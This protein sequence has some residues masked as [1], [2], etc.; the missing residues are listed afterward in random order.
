MG[1]IFGYYSLRNLF[2]NYFDPNIK[3]HPNFPVKD[4]ELTLI[5]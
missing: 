5:V 3:L 2:E 1:G 4:E